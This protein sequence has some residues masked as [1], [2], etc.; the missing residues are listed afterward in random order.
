MLQDPRTASSV[1]HL[2]LLVGQLIFAAVAL[3]I[4]RSIAPPEGLSAD[5]LLTA[6]S[7]ATLLSIVA[8]WVLSRTL[9]RTAVSLP[10]ETERMAAGLRAFLLRIAIL[11][12]SGF[13]TLLAYLF[14][15][16]NTFLGIFGVNVIA[17]VLGKASDD[18]W[19]S[20]QIGN[21]SRS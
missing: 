13:L 1:I 4:E 17:L 2:A 6:T 10:A 8:S 16:E 15:G 3:V 9:L 20:V 5:L 7:I 19:E 11:E 12:F 14:T 18:E 21:T